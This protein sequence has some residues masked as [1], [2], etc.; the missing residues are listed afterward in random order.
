MIFFFTLDETNK[1]KSGPGRLYAK[2]CCCF[3]IALTFKRLKYPFKATLRI[4]FVFLN[5]ARNEPD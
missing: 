5:L 4:K 3:T 2:Q 1:K